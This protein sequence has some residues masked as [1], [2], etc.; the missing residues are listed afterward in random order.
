MFHLLLAAVAAADDPPTVTAAPGKGITVTSADE[1]FSMN[2][3]ARVQLRQSEFVSAPDA[4]GARDFTMQTQVY[5]ARLWWG[6]HVLNKDTKYLLQLAVSPRDFRDGA[7]SP[8]FDAYF[9]LTY[10]PN[11]SVRVGQ[12][13]VPFDRLRT[14]R[15][16]SLQMI[17]R[18]R[19][20]SEL[21]LDRDI[22]VYAYS[23]HLGGADSPFAYRLGVFG[24][25]GIH[26]LTAHPPGGM[27]VGRFEYR[28]LGP[29][30]D[31]SEGDLERRD[32]PGL[33]IGVAGAYNHASTRARSTTSTTFTGGTANYA[34]FAA[35]AV[36]KYAGFAW[37]NE[38]VT[39]IA[40]ED[41]IQSVADD[42]TPV[43]EY[44][45]SGWGFVSQPSMMVSD[46]VEVAARYGRLAALDGTD[47]AYISDVEA[48]ANELGLGVNVY[49]NAH[50]FKIQNGV[51]AFFGDA[52]SPADAELNVQSALDVMF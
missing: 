21:T 16:F 26:Q 15:E 14:I 43:T 7:T 19:V 3:R 34:H 4:D 32:T 18:P 28:P 39:R 50:R 17:D 31:D 47:P 29:V 52:A 41:E 24:G 40:T 38:F 33:A 48:R 44:T 6:G 22:G 27:V 46:R 8:I 42:G 35:D 25:S 36:F 20:V 49:L 1:R 5:T 13:F 11:L 10:N 45:R 23:D 9:D 12:I 51:A 37:E 30:D 2:L